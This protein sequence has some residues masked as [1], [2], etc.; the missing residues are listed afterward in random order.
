MTSP[1]DPAVDALL[2][3][4]KY[5]PIYGGWLAERQRVLSD[6]LAGL[7]LRPAKVLLIN[8]TLGLTL[9]PS[10]ADFFVELR[11]VRPDIEVTSASYFD[12]IHELSK[13]VARR[14][15][16]IARVTDVGAWSKADLDR[17]DLIV[18][19]GPSELLARL[20]A[21]EGLR[22]KLVLL[23][24]AFYH[25]MM[26]S[27]PRFLAPQVEPN[28]K[29]GDWPSEG[30]ERQREPVTVYSCQPYEK[31]AADL[32]RFFPLSRFSVQ[33]FNY[34]PLGFGRREYYRA[35][36]KAFDV[37]LLGT[38]GRDYS[39][40]DPALLGGL[41]FLFLGAVE[42][43]EGLA[44]LRTRA[45]VTA[46]ARVDENE[47][48]KLLSLCRLV[49]IPLYDSRQNVFLSVVDALASGIPIVVRSRAGR[50]FDE[51]SNGE[52]APV[53]FH[54]DERA[55]RIARRGRGPGRSST[56]RPADRRWAR[57]PSATPRSDWT[58]LPHPRGGS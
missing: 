28:G 17:Y 48:A 9:Y 26:Q 29:A 50:G 37:A 16:P 34:I 30:M 21:L 4:S 3:R 44:S 20:M 38:D 57:R 49:A 10:I 5:T 39:L 24:L 52:Q 41:R 43:A 11:R 32:G 6:K 25:Q 1:R 56:A 22:P 47:F 51:C 46:V 45:E 58:S 33:R 2:A 19:V 12:E 27:Q 18:A 53:L 36:E 42:R 31:L 13:D 55:K 23:D 7:P 8:A 15:L 54:S 40:L 35:G 14:G